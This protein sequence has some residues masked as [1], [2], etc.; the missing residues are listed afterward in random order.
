[1]NRCRLCVIP[2][3]R[4]DTPFEDGVCSACRSFAKR[5]KRDWPALEAE[6]REIMANY[7][8]LPATVYDCIVAS[9]GGKDSHWQV[10]KMIEMGY[11][12]LVVTASTCMLTPIGRANI[13]NLGRYADTIEITPNRAVRAKLNRLGLELVGDI[14]WPEHATIFNTPWKIAQKMGIPI[15]IYGE[16]PQEAYGGP[17]GTEEA[18]QMSQ[19][20]VT[21]FG[22][23]LG[24]RASDLVGQHGLTADDLQPYRTLPADDTAA[25]R[26]GHFVHA[27]FLGS[28]FEWDSERNALVAYEHGMQ[29]QIPCPANWWPY[30]NLDNAMTGIHDH[31]MYRKYG[32]GRAAAQI[33]VDVRRGKLTRAEALEIVRQRDGVFPWV[34]AGIHFQAVLKRLQMT[35]GEFWRLAE[36][37]TNRELFHDPMAERPLLK[38]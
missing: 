2:D 15:V 38:E 32:Y 10:L 9:S 34:Y 22:G 8:P 12:P 20:W 35:E 13:D 16:N 11:R 18:H 26:A 17:E 4:P 30:E 24:L 14:S 21:E 33:S 29:H 27:L 23:F 36:R 6:F 19:R 28:F 37:F 1:M 25:L 31:F 5:P 3:T 7:N